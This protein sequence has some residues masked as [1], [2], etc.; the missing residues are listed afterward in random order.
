MSNLAYWGLFV[1]IL[2]TTLVGVPWLIVD[3]DHE[4]AAAGMIGLALWILY[5]LISCASSHNDL[6]KLKRRRRHIT[7]KGDRHG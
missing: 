5:A 1:A 7:H 4:L 2:I 6:Q 3:I